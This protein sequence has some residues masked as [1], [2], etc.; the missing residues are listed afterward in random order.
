MFFNLFKAEL[1]HCISGFL[2]FRHYDKNFSTTHCAWWFP[3]FPLRWKKQTGP[4][5]LD[6]RWAAEAA[7][8][9]FPGSFLY[10]LDPGN[11][12]GQL[13]LKK[14][15]L[16]SRNMIL[17][18]LFLVVSFPSWQN[19]INKY[20][21]KPIRSPYNSPRI[22]CHR[23][24]AKSKKPIF[25]LPPFKNV[26]RMFVETCFKLTFLFFVIE[27]SKSK[28]YWEIPIFYEKELFSWNNS[29][30]SVAMK[31]NYLRVA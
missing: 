11:E 22:Y 6:H 12:V 5:E 3:T 1:I 20:Y 27:A 30:S 26:I 14:A 31:I 8:R 13:Y 19:K 21:S 18:F 2:D 10:F 29:F 28:H 16:G 25:S 4:S 9:L 23:L 15:S 24:L 7:V 17:K